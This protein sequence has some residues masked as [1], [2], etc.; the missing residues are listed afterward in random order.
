MQCQHA[1][2]RSAAYAKAGKLVSST[3]ACGWVACAMIMIASVVS[4]IGETASDH[5]KEMMKFIFI[6]IMW[7]AMPS[8]ALMS[9]WSAP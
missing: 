7:H 5:V 3:C 6:F 9:V 1:S 2:P 8:M 4:G